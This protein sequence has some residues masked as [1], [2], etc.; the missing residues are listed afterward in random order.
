MKK[1]IIFIVLSLSLIACGSSEPKYSN[2]GDENSKE[3]LSKLF[4][5]NKLDNFEILLKNIEA[6]NSTN[7]KNIVTS[8]KKLKFGPTD[9]SQFNED[10]TKTNNHLNCRES[11]ALSILNSIEVKEESEKGTYL[12]FDSQEI[13]SFPELK[14]I[15][16]C[17]FFGLFNEIDAKNIEEK[18]LKTFLQKALDSKN[19]HFKNTNV[20]TVFAYIYDKYD[21]VLFVGHAGIL[22][23]DQNSKGFYFFEKLSYYEPYQLTYFKNKSQLI[24]LLKSR[25]TFNDDVKEPIIVMDGQVLE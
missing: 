14:N 9:P 21:Q 10:Y 22:M 15:N 16:P 8:W 11:V 25:Y 7:E 12:M 24:K 18:N 23:E 19:I 17:K 1:I 5:K 3:I 13:K 4:E 20:K 2:L 6:F